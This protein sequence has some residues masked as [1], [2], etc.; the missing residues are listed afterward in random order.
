MAIYKKPT[1]LHG[2]WA[3][4]SE[5]TGSRSAKI[6][7]ETNPVPSTFTNKDGS[8]K[9]QDVCKVKFE[10]VDEPL[11]LNLNKATIA[12]LIDAFGE[13]SKTWQGHTLEVVTEKMRVAGKAVTVLYLVPG[14]YE[15]IDDENGYARIAGK[16]GMHRASK[17][18]PPLETLNDLEEIPL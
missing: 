9:I 16:I 2:K 10:G 12:G 13:D 6:V 5:L 11:N 18:M 15:K 8:V 7:S 4:A 3:K 14:G 17:P 1:E